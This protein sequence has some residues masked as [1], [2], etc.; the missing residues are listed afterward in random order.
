LNKFINKIK[1]I[2]ISKFNSFY[3]KFTN[4][5][6]PI[7]IQIN[8]PKPKRK[9]LIYEL[10]GNLYAQPE[11]NT[12]IKIDNTDKKIIKE[13]IKNPRASFQEISRKTNINHETIRYRIHNYVEKKFITNFGLLHDFHKYE[14]YTTYFLLNLK[15]LNEKKFK[16]FLLTNKNIF[17]SA[18]LEG[19]YNCIIYLVSSNPQEVG[20][21]FS[22]L[23]RVLETSIKKIDLLFL[24]KIHK[25]IQ[26]PEGEI[27]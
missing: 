26:F 6:P 8:L 18:K 19:E 3:K 10:N 1:E 9:N 4:I 25:Y 27:E 16:D 21:N 2:K 12:K 23:M 17:Y 20:K 15:N 24:D 14:L 5:I 11:E 7:D 22:N 13:L